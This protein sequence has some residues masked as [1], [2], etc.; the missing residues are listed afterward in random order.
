M[1]FRKTKRYLRKRV[2]PVTAFDPKSFRVKDV[3][4]KG[5]TKLIVGC[6]KGKYKQGRCTIGMQTQAVIGE[7]K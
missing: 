7:R 6:P 2:K 5:H 4:R 1:K 3:G